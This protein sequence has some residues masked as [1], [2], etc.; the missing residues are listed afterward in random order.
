LIIVDQVDSDENMPNIL[1]K[2]VPTYSILGVSFHQKNLSEM[3]SVGQN[4][5]VVIALK[6]MMEVTDV[7]RSI[8]MLSTKMEEETQNQQEDPRIKGLELLKS[9]P[10]LLKYFKKVTGYHH[11]SVTSILDKILK[12]DCESLDND[13]VII[14]EI[15]D[16]LSKEY[17]RKVREVKGDFEEFRA[18]LSDEKDK[19]YF[20]NFLTSAAHS[21]FEERQI[22]VDCRYSLWDFR[23][24]HCSYYHRDQ[25]AT[26]YLPLNN[27]SAISQP[28]ADAMI[29]VLS[30]Y[31]V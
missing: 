20:D 23:Y 28:V 2:D 31:L 14:S 29:E 18:E 9:S 21:C 26:N 16:I 6:G 3:I 25:S 15:E 7:L 17:G 24:I 27:P 12:F 22:D 13:E 10:T 19:E 30:L 5:K 1:E 11:L 4:D 8:H